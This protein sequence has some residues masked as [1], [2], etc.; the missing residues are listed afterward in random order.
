MSR[1]R[2]VTAHRSPLPDLAPFVGPVVRDPSG[3]DL[4]VL[5]GLRVALVGEPAAVTRT[6]PRLAG[7]VARCKVLQAD[8]VWVL[9]TRGPLGPVLDAAGALVPAPVRDHV[10]RAVAERGLARGVRDGWT[11]RHL[12]P[13]VPPRRGSVVRVDGYHRALRRDDVE[14]IGWPVAAVVAEGIR[15]ADGIEHHVDA[16]VVAG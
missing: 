2:P 10:V 3:A 11:R 5:G 6:L 1:R 14:L 13:Q 7:R 12:T 8:G 9:P 4:E 16:I 15:T